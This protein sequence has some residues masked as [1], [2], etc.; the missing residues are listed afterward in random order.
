[1]LGEAVFRPRAKHAQQQ[2]EA[3]TQKTLQVSDI[4]SIFDPYFERGGAPPKES[5]ATVSPGFHH[6]GAAKLHESATRLKR[7]GCG[8]RFDAWR[9][10]ALPAYGQISTGL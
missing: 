7:H 9:A 6:L 1:R 8:P 5:Q 3:A 4:K 10:S 2:N